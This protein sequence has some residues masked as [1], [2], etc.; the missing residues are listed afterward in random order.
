MDPENT[1]PVT[2]P[3]YMPPIKNSQEPSEPNEQKP[4]TQGEPVVEEPHADLVE[5]PKPPEQL[6]EKSAV[7]L[8]VVSVRTLLV[9][10]VVLLSLGLLAWYSYQASIAKIST[11]DPGTGTLAQQENISDNSQR[12]TLPTIGN[13]ST[14]T[15]KCAETPDANSVCI[16]GRIWMKK[17]LNVGTF[18]DSSKPQT[19]NGVIEKYCYN[20]DPENC[21]IYGGLYQWD[22]MLQYVYWSGDTSFCPTGFHVP[23]DQEWVNL[24][25]ALGGGTSANTKMK[26]GGSSGFD[27]TFGGYFSQGSHGNTFFADFG[28]ANYYWSSMADQTNIEVMPDASS[29]GI[30]ANKDGVDRGVLWTTLPKGYALSIRCIKNWM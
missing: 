1:Q 14:E 28:E 30:Y 9:I 25:S 3:P 8:P 2:P 27:A 23:N 5:P 29:L 12:A 20:N 13:G 26:V 19:N 18:I 24:T 17:N 4:L 16:G 21:A 11:D 22:E 6:S 10:G 7:K 15:T